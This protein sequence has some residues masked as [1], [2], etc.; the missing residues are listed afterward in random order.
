MWAVLCGVVSV[1]VVLHQA[2]VAEHLLQYSIFVSTYL[3]VPSPLANP[4]MCGLHGVLQRVICCV[5]YEAEHHHSLC[6]TAF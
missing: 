4:N 6:H 1:A 3:D 5:P 2:Y